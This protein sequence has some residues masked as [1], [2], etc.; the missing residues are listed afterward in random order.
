[1]WRS[2]NKSPFSGVQAV[3]GTPVESNLHAFAEVK[4]YFIKVNI[5]NFYWCY[6]EVT[7]SIEIYEGIVVPDLRDP[8]KETIPCTVSSKL[9]Q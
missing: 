6:K 2:K 5:I 7:K 1:M 9:C 4:K 8:A 3:H